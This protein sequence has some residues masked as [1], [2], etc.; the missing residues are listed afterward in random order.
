MIDKQR[1]TSPVIASSPRRCSSGGVSRRHFLQ[2]GVAATLCSSW[3]VCSATADSV[4]AD[5]SSR[6]RGLLV[7]GLVGDALGGPVEFGDEETVAPVMP[8]TRHWDDATLLDEDRRRKL[9][10]TLP[11]LDYQTLRPETAPYGPWV[12]RAPAGTVTDDSRHKI[13]LMR[14]LEQAVEA[15]HFP[16][17]DRM[18]AEQ[19]IRFRPLRHVE[20]D[21]SLAQLCEIGLREY[22]MAARWKLGE[23]DLRLARPPERLWSGIHNCSGQMMMPPLAA[24]FPGDPRA[25]Y[26]AIYALDFIDTGMA[27][28]MTAALGAGLSAVLDPQLDDAPV[29][30]RW[31]VLLETMRS[32]DPY[33][34]AAVPFAGRPLTRWMDT[35]AGFAERAGG[36]P[37][38]LFRMLEEE[39]QPVYWW[40]AHYTLLVPLAMLHFCRFDPLAA[41]HLTLDFGHDTDSYAQVLGCMAGAV[42]GENLFPEPMR[43][44]VLTRLRADFGE[45]LAAWD[46]I[47]EACA[48]RH[49]QGAPVVAV[50]VLSP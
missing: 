45:D 41:L 3:H 8:G 9:A 34:L 49:R 36:V 42:C 6:R 11:L 16:V 12:E 40:D 37:K 46:R 1:A 44:A 7:G 22:R 5:A 30:H 19:L 33:E 47:L 25:A 23:R 21:K 20:A 29:A 10:A 15:D 4:L 27:R 14:T 17:T 38:R 43:A 26:L 48:K 2:S 50:D 13:I 24:A 31:Q 39:G 32:T 28:D 35:A 18:L